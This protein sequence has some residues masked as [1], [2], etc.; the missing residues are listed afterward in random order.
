MINM[1]PEKTEQPFGSSS[2]SFAIPADGSARAHVMRVQ[3]GTRNSSYQ[4]AANTQSA[5]YTVQEN[6]LVES[7]Y[8]ESVLSKKVLD[9]LTE[10]VDPAKSLADIRRVL[11]GPTRQL[12]D[13][14]MEEIL[15]I[16]EESDKAMQASLRGLEDQFV[17]LTATS[18]KQ[19]T[20]LSD[21]NQ[22]IDLQTEH[23]NLE[24]QRSA[25]TQQDML[26]ELFL[27]FDKKLE[28]MTTQ[29]NQQIENLSTQTSTNIQ[30]LVTDFAERMQ[31][32]TALTIANDDKIVEQIGT[33]INR[34]EAF[35]DKENHRHIAAF[36]N[37]FSDLADR[38]LALRSGQNN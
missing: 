9:A 8:P 14:R 4:A 33:R 23:L 35:A 34:A 15:T 30:S 22:R 1:A 10:D 16:L 29:M 17:S 36:A 6:A 18:N 2:S 37:G 19:A 12:H 24:L 26:S 28:K 21:A 11:V 20:G 31:E 27:M 7:Q 32:L 25:K 13:A 3:S 38:F 5:K